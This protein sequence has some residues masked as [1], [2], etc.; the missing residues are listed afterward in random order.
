MMVLNGTC[1]YSIRERC[2]A[3]FFNSSRQIT[4]MTTTKKTPKAKI[5]QYKTETILRH[6]PLTG[7]TSSISHWI[8]T[9]ATSKI[10]CTDAE[11]SG[12]IP[13]PG[14][15]VTVRI[16]DMWRAKPVRRGI[17]MRVNLFIL[18]DSENLLRGSLFAD[19]SETRVADI[20]F[21]A[22]LVRS[23]ERPS[24]LLQYW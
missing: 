2:Q 12:P 19:I 16:C 17:A 24:L 6:C 3:F 1:R 11:I 7:V 22:P 20:W 13:S 8:G 14:M 10:F 4:D 15:R 23:T 9:P 5:Q 18:I 21:I